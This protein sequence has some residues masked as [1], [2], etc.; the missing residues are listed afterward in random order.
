MSDDWFQKVMTEKVDE[1]DYLIENLGYS[2][3]P[4]IEQYNLV[5]SYELMMDD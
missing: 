3:S 2:D 4:L 5:V 1:Y